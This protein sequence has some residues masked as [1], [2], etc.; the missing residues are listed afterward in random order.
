MANINWGSVPDWFAGSG[1]VLAL[2]FARRAVKAAH[3]TN[4]Q[5]NK[6]LRQLEAAEQRRDDDER[7][8]QASQLAVWLVRDGDSV[9]VRF[10]NTSS[11]PV[12]RLTITSPLLTGDFNQ[13]KTVPVVPPTSEPSTLHDTS[14][15]LTSHLQYLTREV[16]Y[17]ND[18][19]GNQIASGEWRRQVAKIVSTA[20][21]E[22]INIHYLDSS[23]NWWRRNSHGQLHEGEKL[24]I[25][26]QE[27]D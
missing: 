6:Q 21:E 18:A 8:R 23:G 4:E 11:Q 14:R 25:A 22:G 12:Y 16:K 3:A 17:F 27:E 10:A 1:A 13:V 15:E 20:I 24:V 5:Q 9:L 19:D 26:S 7:R 2:F